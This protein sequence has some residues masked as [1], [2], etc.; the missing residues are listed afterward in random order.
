MFRLNFKVLNELQLQIVKRPSSGRQRFETQIRMYET[1]IL[2]LFD[3]HMKRGLKG[4]HKS[5]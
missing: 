4:N 3:M 1:F 5:A 2:P